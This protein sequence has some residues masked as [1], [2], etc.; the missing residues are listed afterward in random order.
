M[1]L[2]VRRLIVAN[3]AVFVLTSM[4]PGLDAALAFA[5]LTAVSRPWTILTYMFVHGGF[6]HILWNMIGL[7]F[8]GPRVETRLGSRRFLGLYFTSGIAGAVLTWLAPLAGAGSPFVRIVGASAA[9][10]GVFLAYARYWPH[11][12][13]LLWFVVP[14]PAYVLIIGLTLISVLGG[15]GR[16]GGFEADVAHWGHLGGFVGGYF[17]LKVIE[18]RTGSARFRAI[19]TATAPVPRG[20]AMP[21]RWLRI[22]RAGLHPVNRD[23]L[24]RVLVKLATGGPTGLT[25]DER[26]FLDRLAGA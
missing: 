8:F 23:E 6:E 19:A 12:R 21:D 10:F 15:L 20:D 4:Q 24:E 25:T 2:W 13:I 9:I 3:I 14:V 11:D 1:T 18:S 17:Y 16:L 22:D 5:P 7:F 26:A